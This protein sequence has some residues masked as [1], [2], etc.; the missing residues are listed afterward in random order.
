MFKP[1]LKAQ[2]RQGSSYFINFCLFLSSSIKDLESGLKA[3]MRVFDGNK[4]L[5]FLRSILYVVTVLGQL[6]L[7]KA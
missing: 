2:I 5:Y 7:L 6:H 4:N 3:K 1:R